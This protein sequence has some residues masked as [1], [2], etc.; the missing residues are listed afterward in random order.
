LQAG[1]APCLNH[2]IM[3]LLA[4]LAHGRADVLVPLETLGLLAP[5]EHRRDILLTREVTHE[6]IELNEPALRTT[7]PSATAESWREW[8]VKSASRSIGSCRALPTTGPGGVGVA[9]LPGAA[10]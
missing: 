5:S 9:L 2:A 3:A 10:L 8:N 1:G 4:S 6:K 7:K